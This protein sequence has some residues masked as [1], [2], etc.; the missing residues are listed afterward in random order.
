MI[1]KAQQ[2]LKT[3]FGYDEFRPLQQEVISNVLNRRDTLAI[4]PTGS[5]KSICYQIPALIFDGLTVVI[6]P[7]ISL[8]KDQV[9][10]LNALGVD[11]VYLN[12]SLSPQ[13]YQH[14]IGR[15]QSGRARLLYVAPETL[16]TS[17]VQELLSTQKIDCFTI[18]EA[19]CISE[20]GHDFR[21]EYRKL[22]EAR[23]K[24]PQAV[25]IA[26]TATA[27][28]RVQQDIKL[29]LGFSQSNSY[30]ASFNRT[31]LFLRVVP[32]Q[33]PAI[34]T[35]E[36]LQEYPEKSGIIYCF[37][38]QQV[39][40]LAEFLNEEGFSVKPYHAGMSD[41]ERKRNQELFIRADVQ[42]IVSTIAFGMGINK[43]NVRFVI[44]FD[45]PK[46]IESYYQQIGRAGRDGLRSECLL[47]F[48]YGDT[49][50]IRFLID[51]KE[52]QERMVA[53][54]HLNAM[55]R[56]AETDMCRRI[57]L[58]RYFGEEYRV[59]NCGMCDNCLSGD[60]KQEDVTI[61]AQ[62]FFSCIKRTNEMF[63]A[64]H[65]IDVLRGSSAHKVLKFGHQ[66]LSTYGVGTEYSKKQWHHLARQFIQQE[67]LEQD[68]EYGS[69]KLT[70]KAR[71]V[72][73]NDAKVMGRVQQ[74]R[75][76][77]K[78]AQ[79]EELEYDKELFDRL[80]RRRKKLAEMEQMPPYV[81]FP[82]SAL[83]EMASY[84]PQTTENLSRMQGVGK[85]KLNN[86]GAK[87]LSD[88]IGYCKRKNIQDRT[89]QK[90][91]LPATLTRERKQTGGKRK[92]VI[93]GEAFN[94]GRSIEDLAAMH[95]VKERTIIKHLIQYLEHG[96]SLDSRRVE[97][98][99]GLPEL[100]EAEKRAVLNH[101]DVHGHEFLKP[102]YEAFQEKID[103]ESLEILR[104][105]CLGRKVAKKA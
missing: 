6:S 90:G 44:H 21:P 83:I 85:V 46:N 23:R 75:I 63:G 73:F 53:Q 34:Q 89:Y 38:R 58:L 30:L 20:W 103:Y 5:G 65:I 3:V 49:Q 99:Y 59:E 69:L 81:I 52:G 22:I 1:D 43:P 68:P 41:I 45:L 57:P 100:S 71:E 70:D 80:R 84:F 40:D 78:A 17:R 54:T 35:I 64:N 60:K 82:D 55:L 56:F 39:D 95:K 62:K 42:I 18:D 51:Q 24:Y 72:L 4:M 96:H 27:T 16:L 102:A 31:N 94:E 105:V 2:L 93:V 87:F 26:L 14:N 12:S 98:L 92:F 79:T 15:V 47:L 77:Y 13:E 91:R 25:C 76:D 19:H 88:I 11:A 36:F 48:G 9:E 50:K 104:L 66:N 33:N 86:Y 7:L 29:T 10:Q 101:F 28:R 61:A 32:K 74:E 8:M 37:S 67:L 97:Y